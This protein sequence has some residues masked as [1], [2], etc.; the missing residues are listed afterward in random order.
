MT[1]KL[2]PQEQKATH[3]QTTTQLSKDALKEQQQTLY[4]IEN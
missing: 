3:H 2:Q 4:I 1:S